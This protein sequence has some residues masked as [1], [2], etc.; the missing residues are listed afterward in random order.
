VIGRI[1]IFGETGP[2]E[3]V[4]C[5][6]EESRHTRR[7]ERRRGALLGGLLLLGRGLATL[8]G[9]VGYVVAALVDGL[10]VGFVGFV[11]LL[12]RLL[13]GLVVAHGALRGEVLLGSGGVIPY[14]GASR[15]A[16]DVAH[17]AADLHG[18]GRHDGA[19]GAVGEVGERHHR[20]LVAVSALERERAQVDPCAS[21]H[22][23]VD[24]E[25]LGAARIVYRIAGVGRGVGQC[26]VADVDGIF[27]V[28][29]YVGIPCGHRRSASLLGRRLAVGAVLER[30]LRVAEVGEVVDESLEFACGPFVDAVE[31]L[32]ERLRE[33]LAL[34][35]GVVVDNHLVAVGVAFAWQHHVCA[36]VLEHRHDIG[37]H[38]RHREDILDGLEQHGALPLP[39][40]VVVIA[41]MRMPEGYDVVVHAL[42][43]LDRRVDLGD[44]IGVVAILLW[45][46]VDLMDV[47]CQRLVADVEVDAV[48]ADGVGHRLAHHRGERVDQRARD[49]HVGEVLVEAHVGR[50]A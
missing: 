40:A 26:L 13:V 48:V 8:L 29:G 9:V 5:P 44:E 20:L 14:V 33:D 23:L 24:L 50:A 37:E 7:A 49:R 3:P 38:V 28:L 45:E 46:L 10:L 25:L 2:V 22:L 1:D 32:I 6:F 35:V 41:A 42:R 15:A 12:V 11:G 43:G 27:A 47:I 18:V 39:R 16:G 21:A 34:V 36:G 30:I 31:L 17:S 4:A 19:C